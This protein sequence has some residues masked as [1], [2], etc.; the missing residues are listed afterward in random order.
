ML[1]LVSSV[2]PATY[3]DIHQALEFVRCADSCELL[4][5][6]ILYYRYVCAEFELSI[7]DISDLLWLSSRT[8]HRYHQDGVAQLTQKLIAIEVAALQQAV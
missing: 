2:Y 5:C 7:P 8:V 1:G 4:V 6:N 3:A